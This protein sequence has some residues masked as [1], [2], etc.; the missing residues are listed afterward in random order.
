MR[1]RIAAYKVPRW[2]FCVDELPM[3][4][5]G[6]IRR[7]DLRRRAADD[8]AALLAAQSPSATSPAQQVVPR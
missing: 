4:G 6:K 2:V 8:V 1:T 7:V 5:T 3:G